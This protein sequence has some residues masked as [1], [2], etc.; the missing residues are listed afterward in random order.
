MTTVTLLGETIYGEP[1]GNYDGSTEL[2]FSEE[3][4]KAV[5]YYKSTSTSQTVRFSTN[6][7]VG[8]IVLQASLDADPTNDSDWFDAYTFPGD[9][10]IDG[11]TA[12]TTAYSIT[13]HGNFTWIRAQVQQFTGGTID[14]VTLTY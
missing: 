10:T 3:R 12:I 9:S 7:F 4:H 13:L 8:L 14:S 6:D 2:L 11:S 1:S 5:G